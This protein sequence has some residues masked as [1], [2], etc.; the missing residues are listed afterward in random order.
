MREDGDRTADVHW[1]DRSIASL[2]PPLGPP[3]LFLLILILRPHLTLLSAP[4][5]PHMCLLFS[6]SSNLCVDSH[7]AFLLFSPRLVFAS[8]IILSSPFYFFTRT[9]NR[10]YII[11]D[12]KACLL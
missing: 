6:S 7:P 1:T 10:V 2:M 8:K 5:S 9:L 4:L 3:R 12:L 11:Y